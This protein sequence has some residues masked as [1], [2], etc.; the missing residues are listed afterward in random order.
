MTWT[1]VTYWVSSSAALRA[2]DARADG[3]LGRRVAVLVAVRGQPLAAC[4]RDAFGDAVVVGRVALTATGPVRQHA[5]VVFRSGCRRG[6]RAADSAGDDE[7]EGER[8]L[9]HE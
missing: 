9:D 3:E 6:G 8:D 4:H 7:R 2:V 1:C 5:A